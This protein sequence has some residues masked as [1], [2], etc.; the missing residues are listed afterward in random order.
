MKRFILFAVC[1]VMLI[2]SYG[3]SSNGQ[4]AEATFQ[5]ASKTWTVDFD[6]DLKGKQT[7]SGY[8]GDDYS[9]N[10][11]KDVTF[12]NEVMPQTSEEYYKQYESVVAKDYNN[13]CIFFSYQDNEDTEEYI[14]IESIT[15]TD[16]NELA[17]LDAELKDEEYELVTSYFGKRCI[18]NKSDR[19]D[20]VVIAFDTDNESNLEQLKEVLFSVEAN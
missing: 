10:I 12:V 11:N 1:A 15:P 8:A 16:N 3:C 2:S 14:L 19:S 20:A 18:V 6:V 4:K 5:L 17:K 9:I 13:E 7:D